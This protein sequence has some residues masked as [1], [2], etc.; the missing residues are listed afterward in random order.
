[1]R[2]ATD[3]DNDGWFE[4]TERVDYAQAAIDRW[5]ESQHGKTEPGVYPVVHD[6]RQEREAP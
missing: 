2:H 6:V 5:R 1:M 3:P 4:V